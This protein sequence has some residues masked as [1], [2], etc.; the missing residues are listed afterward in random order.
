MMRRVIVNG[1]K[2]AAKMNG[3]ARNIHLVSS[4]V[5]RVAVKAAVPASARFASTTAISINDV[6]KKELEE[7]KANNAEVDAD[8]EDLKKDILKNFTMHEEDGSGLVKLVG[9][10]GNETI[11]VKFDVQNVQEEEEEDDFEAEL[12]EDDEE[13]IEGKS[14]LGIYFEV[15]ITKGKDSAIFGCTAAESVHI[16][17]LRFVSEKHAHDS[18]NETLYQGPKFED[19]EESVQ[20]GF[21]E[22]LV[23][24]H[25]DDDLAYFILAYSREKE[26]MEYTH[27]LENMVKFTK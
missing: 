7:E 11:E 17:Q 23:E 20:A 24:R 10:F 27:F 1:S 4:A 6:L 18:E 16:G 3:S 15:K 8:L 13:D 5:A 25:I 2:V 22:Y 9:K 14:G 19:L 12:P 26:Q 21:Q